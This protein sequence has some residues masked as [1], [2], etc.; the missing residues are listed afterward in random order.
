MGIHGKKP[1]WNVAALVLTGLLT[2]SCSTMGSSGSL[3]A[4]PPAS[5]HDSF[6]R[7]GL[8]G[9]WDLSDGDLE[10]TVI[11]DC[12][13]TGRYEWQDGQIV[14]MVVR[15]HYWSGV[16]SQ[17]GNDR[18]GGFALVLSDDHTKAEGRWW[19]TR[20][21][22]QLMAPSEGGGAFNLARPPS[23]LY[24]TIGETDH[25]ESGTGPRLSAHEPDAGTRPSNTHCSDIAA[26]PDPNAAPLP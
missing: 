16:W 8:T 18:E 17:P 20:I 1:G 24:Q 12:R 23:P 5:G 4:P 7:T 9:E 10:F 26:Q 2:V 15:G 14:T 22:D 25:P 21:G 3:Q 11:L 19:Y 6:A 13:G